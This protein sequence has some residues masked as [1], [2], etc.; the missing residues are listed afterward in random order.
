M[1]FIYQPRPEEI[2]SMPAAD[3]RRSFLLDALFEAGRL[4]LVYTSVDRMIVGG[5]MPAGQ[6]PLPSLPELGTAS[7]TER[8]EVGL[9]NIG[10]PGA[11][12]AGGSRYELN[13][14]DCL[15]VGLGDE[16]V[17]EAP[18]SGQP[19]Y[20]L[21]SCPAHQ[22]YPTRRVTPAEA[23]AVE[24]GDER[25]ASRRTIRKLIH[26]GGVRSC[27]LVMGITELAPNSVWNTM[28][29]HLH[30]RRS[31]IYLY[32]DLGDELLVHLM[33]TPDRTR[34][35]IVR[36]RQ[37]VVS[38]EWSLHSGAGTA[39]Y[40]FIWGMAGENQTFSDIDPVPPQSLR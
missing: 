32:F 38:P 14:L 3:L 25:H 17:F 36:D 12:S 2:D 24:I 22:R 39:C 37:A 29:P 6:M 16:V 30:S 27:Q 13:R 5:V 4:N 23:D 31:E 8:R 18:A 15:Y 7:F 9:I 19:A 11:I 35:L 28:P 40:R 20:Y 1:R 33:G 26:P 34:H 10:D 21:L